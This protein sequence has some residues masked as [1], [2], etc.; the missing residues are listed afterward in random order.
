MEILEILKYTVPSIILLAGVYFL[1]SKFLEEERVRLQSILR[2]NIAKQNQKIALPLRLQAY[3]RITIFL[4]RL[5]PN[6]LIIR[7]RQPH[8]TVSEFR[9]A[10]TATI[11]AEY[12][13]NLSQQIY[14]SSDIW[15]L[16]SEIKEQMTNLI[17]QL[18]L[19]LPPDASA[20]ELAKAV[21]NYTIDVE[22]GKFPTEIG[23]KYLKNEV[24]GLY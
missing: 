23:L 19:A 24:A 14:V 8:M 9:D 18:A 3:E 21:F 6:S 15:K 12:E 2:Q 13:H 5:H 7:V 11:K 20:V 17:H 16:T 1:V 22:D 10:L 4:E